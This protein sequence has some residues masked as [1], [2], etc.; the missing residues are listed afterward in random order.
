MKATASSAA[1]SL[2]A[3]SLTATAQPRAPDLSGMWSDPPATIEDTFCMFFCTQTVEKLEEL[4][5]DE[6]NVE[7][8]IPA[9]ERLYSLE[10]DRRRRVEQREQQN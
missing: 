4:L 1:A 7:R 8:P 3:L 10:Q 6:A 5:G 2:L 9:F